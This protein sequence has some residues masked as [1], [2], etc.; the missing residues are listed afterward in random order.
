[1]VRLP[2]HN[3]AICPIQVMRKEERHILRKGLT[4][5]L[6]CCTDCDFSSPLHAQPPQSALQAQSDP[7][8]ADHPPQLH[9]VA[10]E[11]PSAEELP[12]TRRTRSP[13]FAQAAQEPPVQV[14]AAAQCSVRLTLRNGT[15]NDANIYTRALH[16]RVSRIEGRS[17]RCSRSLH[18]LHLQRSGIA[19]Y[20]SKS[21]IK[22]PKLT[23][24]SHRQG[25][26]Q[27]LELSTRSKPEHISLTGLLH[28]GLF[29]ARHF[30]FRFRSWNWNKLLYS[31]G[32]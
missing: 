26:P 1:M 29:E 5:F 19:R 22:D 21:N 16:G 2:R 15:K 6:E 13:M 18:R 31:Y 25:H 7:A 11:P 8:P 20:A 23:C 17:S 9:Q 32:Y 24:S 27:V 4:S 30:G 10:Q 3:A 28:L 12:Q 14:E